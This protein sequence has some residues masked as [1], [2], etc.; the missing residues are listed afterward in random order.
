MRRLLVALC[1]IAAA[2]PLVATATA[3]PA[4]AADPFVARGSVEQL[5]T[6]GHTPGGTVTLLD[7]TDAV[8]DSG[9]ADTAGAK[10]FRNVA[11]GGGYQVQTPAGTVGPLTVTSS[12]VNPPDSF[13]AQRALDGPCRRA[14]GT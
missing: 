12:D 8:V 10:L 9:P 2:V 3:T 5:Y 4:A 13:Y 7:G 14:S 11:P 6:Y 1:L